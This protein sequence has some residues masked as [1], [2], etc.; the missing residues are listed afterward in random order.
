MEWKDSAFHRAK[1]K[2]GVSALVYS[3]VIR[4]YKNRTVLLIGGCPLF[5]ASIADKDK[6]VS[7]DKIG[8][9]SAI[10][11]SFIALGLHYFCHFLFRSSAQESGGTNFHRSADMDFMLLQ[12]FVAL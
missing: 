6:T 11:A 4:F 10:E 2:N 8:C 9:T 7:F 5:F 3:I 12:P 1:K